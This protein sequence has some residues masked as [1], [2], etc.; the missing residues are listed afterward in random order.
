VYFLPISFTADDSVQTMS[1]PT[2]CLAFNVIS[3]P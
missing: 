1:S 2:S 3:C